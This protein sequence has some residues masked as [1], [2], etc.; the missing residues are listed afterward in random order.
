MLGSMS[1]FGPLAINMYL[2][3]LPAIGRDLGSST[4][5]IQATVASFMVGIATGQLFWGAVSER[6]GRRLPL[7]IGFSAFLVATFVCAIAG[8]SEVLLV[9]RLCQGLSACAGMVLARAIISDGY[10]GKAAATVLTWQHLI[11]GIAPIFAPLIGGL[12]LVTLGWRSIFW[13][14]LLAAGALMAA[15]WAKLP[16]SQSATAAA[17]ARTETRLAAYW[18]IIRNRRLFAH[19][20]AGGLSAAMLMTWY[21]GASPLFEEDFGW[22]PALSSWV[23]GI[24]GVT[25]IGATQLN[26]PLLARFVPRQIV[27]GAMVGGMAVLVLGLV[28]TLAHPPGVH[29]ITAAGLIL[30]V[31]TFGFISAN[32]QACAL[33]LDRLRGGSISALIG[34]GNYGIGAVIS[35]GVTL[36]PAT[37]GA[38]ML[39]AMTMELFAAWAVLKLLNPQVAQPALAG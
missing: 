37:S 20:L 27:E 2:P 36:L 28:L 10:E 34:A 8:N 39:A 13:V 17:H 38:T 31:T 6:L 15:L 14:L 25:I 3:A 35:S 21:T 12:L 33:G 30:G 23:F 16:E 11:M 1:L 26:R 5:S 24:L 9:A 18:A 22:S 19:V 32:N 7:L 29:A 4:Q